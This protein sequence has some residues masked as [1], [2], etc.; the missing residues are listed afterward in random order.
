[1]FLVSWKLMK[2]ALLIPNVNLIL[3]HICR[4]R[5]QLQ[6][7]N[8]LIKFCQK[9]AGNHL[10]CRQSLSK[11]P[12]WCILEIVV[13]ICQWLACVFG[14]WWLGPGKLGRSRGLWTGIELMIFRFFVRV[15]YCRLLSFSCEMA[16]K[17][18]RLSSYIIL[19]SELRCTCFE[20]WRSQHTITSVQCKRLRQWQW[21]WD[22]EDI[23]Y[24]L[25]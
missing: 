14:R 4:W 15:L 21:N 8:F 9:T 6:Y 13:K 10:R 19:Y 17:V 18:V 22:K 20:K 2:A 24:K 23:R 7:T 11:K 16:H 25:C 3:F 12:N 5:Y 1:M